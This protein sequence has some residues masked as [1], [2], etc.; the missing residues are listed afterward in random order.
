MQ[1]ASIE[2][3]ERT[4]DR[5]DQLPEGP[6]KTAL[7][8]EAVRAAD[9]LAD[10]PWQYYTRHEVIAA[11]FG[12]G[13]ADKMLVALSWCLSRCDRDSDHIQWSPILWQC[14]HALSYVTAFPNITR[15]RIERLSEDII[16]RYREHGASL[17]GPYVF[18]LSNCFA[19]GE[20]DRAKHYYQLW[21][22]APIDEYAES[23]D[24]EEYFEIDYLRSTK[25]KDLALARAMPTLEAP[26]QEDGTFHWLVDSFLIDLLKRGEVE[27][28]AKLFRRAYRICSA[29]SKY[30]HH[31]GTHLAYLALTGNID[32][33]VRLFER[34][35]PWRMQSSV[36]GARF[37]FDLRAWCFTRRLLAADRE[38]IT[39]SLPKDFPLY[40]EDGKYEVSTLH[41]WF[42][43]SSREFETAFNQRNGNDAVTKRVEKIV[44]W[45]DFAVDFPIEE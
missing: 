18:M 27:K 22:D 30:L 20:D 15:A 2:F 44:A 23:P 25:Q 12:S 31:V 32:R 3:I 7:L 6:I 14:K 4:L 39:F 13:E 38:T 43:S 11:A 29:N 21:Q 33:A 8:E 16:T 45:D 35:L 37:N 24:W 19:L 34:H 17:R 1:N 10:V 40:R 41:D 42:E 28:S 36:P 9:A 5:A 26:H